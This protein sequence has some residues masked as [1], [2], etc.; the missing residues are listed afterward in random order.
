MR[1]DPNSHQRIQSILH[2]R[3]RR[4][5]HQDQVC[6]LRI[7][8]SNCLRVGLD[9]IHILAQL[10][11]HMASRDQLGY[12]YWVDIQSHH[13]TLLLAPWQFHRMLHIKNTIQIMNT[14]QLHLSSLSQL[15]HWLSLHVRCFFPR[16]VYMATT[17]I[18]MCTCHEKRGI[19]FGGQDK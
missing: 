13:R 17:T 10:Y 6:H 12:S 14:C 11:T 5:F 15:H 2:S 16:Q 18:P 8:S 1:Q 3:H 4:T 9:C 19:F 7:F